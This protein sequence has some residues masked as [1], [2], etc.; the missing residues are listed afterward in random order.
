M[1]KTRKISEVEMLLFNENM[2][3]KD[4]T[5]E[6]ANANKK[7]EHVSL[8]EISESDVANRRQNT[9]VEPELEP[10][11]EFGSEPNR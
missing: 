2:F 8:E 1:T 3:Y 4:M 7:P 9:E 6:F 5:V 11:S 10:E